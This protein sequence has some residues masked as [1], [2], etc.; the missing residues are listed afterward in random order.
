MET[1]TQYIYSYCG[2]IGQPVKY[3]PGSI[4]IEILL[5]CMFIIPGV[6][7]SVWRL[8]SKTKVCAVCKKDTMIP[9]E[10]PLGQKIYREMYL[11]MQ[12]K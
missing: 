10:T 3:T 12:K 7:Y 2:T 9:L 11:D 4:W 1:G 5:W 8:A 6:I